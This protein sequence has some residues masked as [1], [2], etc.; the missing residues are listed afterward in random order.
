MY[1]DCFP[2]TRNQY[3]VVIWLPL[4]THSFSNY[5]TVNLYFSIIKSTEQKFSQ[6]KFQFVERKQRRIT[7]EITTVKVIPSFTNV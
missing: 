1:L 3:L 6:P 5:W 4:P 2:V 7:K